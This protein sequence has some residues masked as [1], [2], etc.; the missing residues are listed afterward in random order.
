MFILNKAN[1]RG[2]SLIE[3]VFGC[4]LFYNLDLTEVCGM[5]ARTSYKPLILSDVVKIDE[6]VVIPE[7]Y[8]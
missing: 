4:R 8:F 3:E 7:I 1:L 5:F 2:Y 6:W